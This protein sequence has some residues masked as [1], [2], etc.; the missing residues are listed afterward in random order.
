[1]G[2]GRS[3]ADPE[4]S[5]H[6]NENVDTPETATEDASACSRVRMLWRYGFVVLGLPNFIGFALTTG[7]V[8]M[9]VPA[10]PSAKRGILLAAAEA[11]SGFVSVFASIWIA[12]LARIEPGLW[13][14]VISVAWFFVYFVRKNRVP[15]FFRSVSGVLCGWLLW[16]L[17]VGAR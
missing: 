14:F 10:V 2:K 7:V 15:E 12:R 1:M 16:K 17:A 4:E 13:I 8:A 9:V 11:F 3:G 5:L 6:F